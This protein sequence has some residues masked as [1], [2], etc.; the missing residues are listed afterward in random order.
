MKQIETKER[1]S[2]LEGKVVFY[3]STTCSLRNRSFALV[4]FIVFH[5]VLTRSGSSFNEKYNKCKPQVHSNGG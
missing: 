4:T 2:N 5:T 3:I 1:R